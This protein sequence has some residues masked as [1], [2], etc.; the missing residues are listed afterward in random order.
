MDSILKSF[1]KY[2]LKNAFSTVE[3]RNI[4][5]IAH[6]VD[7]LCLNVFND[8][9]HPSVNLSESLMGNLQKLITSEIRVL[10]EAA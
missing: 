6:S 7:L 4:Y 2:T 3:V 8:I 5:Y 10:L 9:L 1:G